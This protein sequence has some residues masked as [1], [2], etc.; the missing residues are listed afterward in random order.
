MNVT[1]VKPTYTNAQSW[2][3]VLLRVFIGWHLL[4][5]GVVKLWNPGWSAGG[6]LMDSQ[7]LF[8]EMFYKMAASPGVLA[9]VDFL[10][11]WGLILIG[12]SLILGAFTRWALI[13]GILLIGLYYLS[14][15][16]L[17]GVK[18][19]L[20][21][22]GSY[23]FVNKNLIEIAAMFV[24]LYFPSSHIMGI[25]RFLQRRK[26]TSTNTTANSKTTVKETSVG[27]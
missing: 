4:Y 2:A 16:A 27:V 22:E 5:E 12:L 6:Y 18:Y 11:V 14:H 9:V 17:I 26:A 19:A 13:G 20:P 21:S 8:E 24:L 7:G 23:L 10:N 1:N 3:L 15:P 25:D